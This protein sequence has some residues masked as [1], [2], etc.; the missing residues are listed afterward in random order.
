MS[1]WL[2]TAEAAAELG[3]SAETLRKWRQ[4][5]VGPQNFK[6]RNRVFYETSALIRWRREQADAN[7]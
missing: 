3:F 5:G 1:R 6:I 4:Q 7:E 2:T